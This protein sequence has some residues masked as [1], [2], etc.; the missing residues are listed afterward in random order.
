MTSQTLL[1]IVGLA[2]IKFAGA[3]ALND[4]DEEGH[5]KNTGP[6]RFE[7]AT[8]PRDGGRSKPG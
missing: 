5:K 7:L 3:Q 8:F 6:T 1:K 2:N 4:I